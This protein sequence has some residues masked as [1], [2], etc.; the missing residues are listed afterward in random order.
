MRELIIIW[1]I[2]AMNGFS[3]AHRDHFVPEAQ[4]SYAQADARYRELAEA[5]VDVTFDPEEKS[6]W[7]GPTGRSRTALF[8]L[9]KWNMESG[10]RRD[11]QTGAG[12]ERLASTGLND[13]G[14]SWCLGQLNLGMVLKKVGDGKWVYD[15]HQTTPEGWSGR[16]LLDDPR[17]CARATLHTLLRTMGSCSHLPW[18][19]RLAAY[20]AGTCDSK[21]GQEISEA[22]M[23]YFKSAWSRYSLKRPKGT[24]TELLARWNEVP[25]SNVQSSVSDP[26]LP[27]VSFVF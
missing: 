15:S 4:E 23:K 6:I 2:A 18:E 17:K 7:G 8:L 25:E 10:F 11:I 19:Q 24:D 27:L 26:S 16:E 13:H 20:A 14:R 3:P 22:R 21:K 12:R 1:L 9:F 5:V